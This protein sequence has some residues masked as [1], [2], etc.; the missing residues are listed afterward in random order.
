M[1]RILKNAYV[2]LFWKFAIA[3]TS[4]V[5]LFGSLNLL[6]IRNQ[7]YNTFEHQIE[8]QGLSIAIGI[9]ESAIDPILFNDVSALNKLLIRTK[10]INPDLE[11][12]FLVSPN[13][14]VIAHTFET[15]TPRNLI[16]ANALPDSV[17]KNTILIHD[18]SKKNRIIRDMA[19]PIFDK[20]L[21]IVRIGLKEDAFSEEIS[22]TTRLFLQMVFV[23]LILGIL[24]SL[25]LSYIISSPLRAISKQASQVNFDSLSEQTD[26]FDSLET[27][28]MNK[29]KNIFNFSDEIDILN[30]TFIQML[31]R[32]K[33]A[34]SELKSTQDSLSQ[35]E[36]MVSVGTLAAGLAH[37]INNPIAG[38]RNCLRRI[39]D[40]PEN[41]KQNAE[42]LDM[43]NEAI[44]KIENVVQ[45][46]LSFSRKQE[47]TFSRIDIIK[48]IENTIGLTNYQLELAGIT[49]KR[50]YQF[51]SL[52]ALASP[53][54]LEQVFVNILLNSIDAIAEKKQQQSELRGEI[55]ITVKQSEGFIKIQFSD[56]GTG[57]P[58]D[59]VASLFDPFFTLKKIRQG[60]GLGMAVSY[61]II[62]SHLGQITGKNKEDGGFCITITLP[63]LQ[64]LKK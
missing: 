53:N 25:A 20:R 46:M 8:K 57:M 55:T 5:L 31:L 11:Y 34:Y 1:K 12:I 27:S 61:N 16:N 32:L 49:L 63:E 14:E 40:K 15:A 4:I 42:Y 23:L 38:I 6:F 47:L 26:N 36:K 58:E 13:N 43:M 7:V 41:I 35:T 52:I 54:H 33:G 18:T 64:N 60:T 10:S 62:S 50:H 48:S 28:R 56:N 59:K 29:W 44:G 45:G 17:L 37:E 39:S 19:I 21:G 3:I 24:A 30:S 22:N 51:Q 2:P 9:A